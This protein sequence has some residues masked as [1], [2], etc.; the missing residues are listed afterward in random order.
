MPTLRVRSATSVK[1]GA[2]TSRRSALRKSCRRTSMALLAFFVTIP[3]RWQGR[4]VPCLTHWQ[5]VWVAA[6]GVRKRDGRLRWQ[7]GPVGL[8]ALW[9]AGV[10]S[11]GERTNGS[12]GEQTTARG[13]RQWILIQLRERL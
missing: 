8:W 11:R 10:I 6:S 12:R 13:E 9:L 4:T 5:A 2:R 3:Y 1:P 7:N